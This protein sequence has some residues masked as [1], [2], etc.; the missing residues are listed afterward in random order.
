MM[1]PPQLTSNPDVAWAKSS[2]DFHGGHTRT[3]AEEVADQRLFGGFRGV[4]ARF[5]PGAKS[6]NYYNK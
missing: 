4:V 2:N 3:G 6:D 5:F 1:Y